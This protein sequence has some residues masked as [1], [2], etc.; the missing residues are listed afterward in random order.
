MSIILGKMITLLIFIIVCDAAK[1]DGFIP[2]NIKRF[3]PPAIATT[4]KQ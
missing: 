1:K 4:R 2:S 3:F